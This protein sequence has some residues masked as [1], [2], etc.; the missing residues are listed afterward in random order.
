MRGV[1]ANG[2]GRITW[3]E[4]AHE[5]FHEDAQQPVYVDGRT[6]TPPGAGPGRTGTGRARPPVCGLNG[7][8]AMKGGGGFVGQGRRDARPQGPG[9]RPV[10]PSGSARGSAPVN[11]SAAGVC[12]E[13][14]CVCARARGRVWV[15]RRC[16]W[17]KNV[18][19]GLRCEAGGGGRGGGQGSSGR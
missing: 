7:D 11:L 9:T 8:G 5:L 6:P 3:D 18:R 12:G 15:G 1:D 2:D 14:V 19:G 10:G 13:C 16:V 4:W 17:L